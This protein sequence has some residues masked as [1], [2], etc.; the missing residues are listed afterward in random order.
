MSLGSEKHSP[1]SLGKACHA[2]GINACPARE[3][4]LPC[5]QGGDY[6][7]TSVDSS[8]IGAGSTIGP[9]PSASRAYIAYRQQKQSRP[10]SLDP[11]S[12]DNIQ[13]GN[14]M[15][16][17]E[18]GSGKRV[19]WKNF[20]DAI[21]GPNEPSQAPSDS[22]DEVYS[23]NESEGFAILN[24]SDFSAM[25]DM[26]RP[27]QTPAPEAAAN[28]SEEQVLINGVE[29]LQAR[30]AELRQ[31][32]SVE[33]PPVEVDNTPSPTLTSIFTRFVEGAKS[34][35]RETQAEP[36][37]DAEPTVESKPSAHPGM[38]SETEFLPQEEVSGQP[39]IQP[40][41]AP[42]TDQPIPVMVSE[43]DGFAGE[44]DLVVSFEGAYDD[45]EAEGSFEKS[46]TFPQLALLPPGSYH[47]IPVEGLTTG[48]VNVLGDMVG[49]VVGAASALRGGA[50]T[51]D[52]KTAGESESGLSGVS[53]D[54]ESYPPPPITPLM[55]QR[56]SNGASAI[57]TG[58]GQ[59][60]RGGVDMVVGSAGVLGGSVIDTAR[61]LRTPAG[62]QAEF[63]AE[64][65]KRT[66][67]RPPP[68]KD[69][70]ELE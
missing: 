6:P 41:R 3:I 33:S 24:E 57:F 50:G 63:E 68:P 13:S 70:Y 14:L 55:V 47:E 39:E 1:C 62:A 44:A 23:L 7:C 8:V 59:V 54:G 48:I 11:L 27:T 10:G 19:S 32:Q 28:S 18:S 16:V 17:E 53:L 61:S 52:K 31:S 46:P 38:V 65:A 69:P 5:L 36:L 40:E 34:R 21:G 42:T 56:L 35:R 64:A 66:D 2:V 30:R 26:E 29:H 60:A 9:S 45:S 25:S 22:G 67:R 20:L 4:G 15:T 51:S 37:S 49:G 43:G 12:P 58:V